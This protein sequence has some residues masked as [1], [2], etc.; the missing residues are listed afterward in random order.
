MGASHDVARPPCD[1]GCALRW[2]TSWVAMAMKITR[3]TGIQRVASHN[4]RN[5][6][7]R[8]LFVRPISTHMAIHQRSK[9]TTGR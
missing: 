7:Q 2:R 9:Q 1:R 3:A 8:Q 6:R 5:P 4:Q